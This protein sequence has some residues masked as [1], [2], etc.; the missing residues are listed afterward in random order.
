M[1]QHKPRIRGMDALRTAACCTAGGNG[2]THLGH[3]A[4]LPKG[5]IYRI[6]EAPTLGFAWVHER[7]R[8]GLASKA[9][10]TRE[11]MPRH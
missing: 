4:T 6:G 8:S 5:H 11:A 2:S 7:R 10:S 9:M 3:V 1:R